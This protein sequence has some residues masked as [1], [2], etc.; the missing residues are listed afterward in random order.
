VSSS[1]SFR[2]NPSQFGPTTFRCGYYKF[3][4]ELRK[5]LKI[6][7]IYLAKA[8]GSEAFLHDRCENRVVVEMAYGASLSARLA[9][10]AAWSTTLF[11]AWLRQRSLRL[12]TR[13][14]PEKAVRGC[15]GSIHST[16]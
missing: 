3:A 2:T 1:K 15:D 9:S 6:M 11:P 16:H 10:Q 13:R 5:V 8:W 4:A 7:F 12:P 14:A